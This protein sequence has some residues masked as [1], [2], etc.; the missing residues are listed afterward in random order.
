M[1]GKGTSFLVFL[2]VSNCTGSNAPIP[3][4][5]QV[6]RI[7]AHEGYEWV[8]LQTEN[9]RVHFPTGSHAQNHQAILRERAEGSLAQVLSRL[10]ETEFEGP[11][12]LFYVDDRSDV[13]ALTGAPATGYSF[14]EDA[15]V[16]LV[17]NEKW[18]PFERHELAHVVTL[19][20]WP[21]PAGMAVVE[22]LATYVEGECGGYPNGRV[23]R[24]LFFQSGSIP[25][26][27]LTSDFRG[28]DDLTAYLQAA[29]IVEYV[30]QT[31][32][33]G[34]L[35]ELWTLGLRAAPDLIEPS[36]E[37]FQESFQNWIEESYEPL[38]EGAVEV[39]RSGG[40]GISA[41]QPSIAP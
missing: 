9:T 21:H 27:T 40:C 19:G 30:V 14:F 4:E 18:R 23:A 33:P 17:F 6:E 15:A 29:A 28:Q 22:G 35:R 5:R 38:P 8:T 36:V 1:K 20:T 26:E 41:L 11:A 24:M 10:G 25:F 32:G 3:Q 12:H 13:A 31:G 39:I 34:A 7:L 16:V 37:D 2:L